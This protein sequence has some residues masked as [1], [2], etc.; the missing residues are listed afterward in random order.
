MHV[1]VRR[2]AAPVMVVLMSAG[3]LELG[4]FF[5]IRSAA[6]VYRIDEAFPPPSGYALDSRYVAPASARCSLLRV[7]ADTCPFGRQDRAQYMRLVDKSRSVGCRTVAIAPIAGQMVPT[8]DGPSIQLQFVDMGFGRA[9]DPFLTPQTIL[10]DGQGRVR[11]QRQG[12]M[13]DLELVL[14]LEALERILQEP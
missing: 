9:L 12:A 2:T 6:A 3:A 14:A 4:L 11:W 5:A 1:L 7:T 13:D 8:E 10:L